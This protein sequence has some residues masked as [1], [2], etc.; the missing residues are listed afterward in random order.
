MDISERLVVAMMQRDIN[1][2][3][4]EELLE[5]CSRACSGSVCPG[6]R[7][8]LNAQK[9]AIIRTWVG[10][11]R[12]YTGSSVVCG[13]CCDEQKERLQDLSVEFTVTDFRDYGPDFR[14]KGV[15]S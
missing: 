9:S 2:D 15:A 13:D 5:I 11:E 6:C 3:T 14:L 4:G 12:R 10:V 7:R 1:A 8:I